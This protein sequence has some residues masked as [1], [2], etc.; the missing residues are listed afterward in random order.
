MELLTSETH[1]LKLDQ[2]GLL[3]VQVEGLKQYY[4][5]ILAHKDVAEEL[6]IKLMRARKIVTE[7]ARRV[8]Q[9]SPE[10]LQ[11]AD[12]RLR[13]LYILMHQGIIPSIY[14][15]LPSEYPLQKPGR[16]I[17]EKEKDALFG[18]ALGLDREGTANLL[19]TPK[20][21]IRSQLTNVRIKFA[22]NKANP[23]PVSTQGKMPYPLMAMWLVRS[24]LMKA[25]PYQPVENQPPFF[26]MSL[27][28]QKA[29]YFGEAGLRARCLGRISPKDPILYESHQTHYIEP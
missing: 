24:N 12:T 18:F 14:G 20:D 5:G 21:T 7:T 25:D 26:I 19:D 4:N 29:T 11:H 8:D 15:N 2:L 16:P 6:D 1:F 28:D 10:L 13:L 27:K 23:M 22:E 9:I 17:T 3:A